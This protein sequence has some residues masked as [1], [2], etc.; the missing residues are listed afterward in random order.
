M[1]AL[2]EISKILANLPYGFLNLFC[3]CKKTYI[4]GGFMVNLC[5]I[6]MPIFVSHAGFSVNHGAIHLWIL[7]DSYGSKIRELMHDM[8]YYKNAINMNHN[9]PLK[10][11]KMRLTLKQLLMFLMSYP[12]ALMSHPHLSNDIL[13]TEKI[14]NDLLKADE[15]GLFAINSFN[16]HQLVKQKT[17]F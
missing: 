15:M 9:L 5:N 10:R 16:E 13:T 4:L 6:D 14:A 3:N 7:D 2:R 1:L 8:V 17:G 12:H 11:I